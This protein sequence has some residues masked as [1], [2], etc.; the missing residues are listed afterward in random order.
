[1]ALSGANLLIFA[2]KHIRFNTKMPVI[3]IVTW[4]ITMALNDPSGSAIGRWLQMV[5]LR[6]LMWLITRFEIMGL[7]NIPATGPVVIIINHIAFLDPVMVFGS[8]P[9]LVVPM[10]KSEAFTLPV[11]GLFMKIYGAIPVRR[12]E[13]DM[14]AIKHAL[15]VLKRGEIILMAPEGTRS[16]THQMQPARDGATMLALRSGAP[17]VPIGVTGTHWVKAH[18]LRLKRPPIRLSVGKPF[19]VQLPSSGNGRFS[20]QEISAITQEAMYRLAAQLPPEF[21]GVYGNSEEAPESY[22]VSVE[23]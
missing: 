16:R 20:R 19:R 14:N 2:T 5:V 7:E 3:C 9:R 1:M 23:P 10:A 8:V 18:W 22:L 12:G 17:I 6:V 4:I 13:V 21:R 15:Q 11:W